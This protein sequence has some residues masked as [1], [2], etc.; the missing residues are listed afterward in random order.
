MKHHHKHVEKLVKKADGGPIFP[1]F[2]E[3]MSKHAAGHP[4]AHIMR[5]AHLKKH[6]AFTPTDGEMPI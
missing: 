2:H 5:Q 4:H 6:D 3:T 1:K